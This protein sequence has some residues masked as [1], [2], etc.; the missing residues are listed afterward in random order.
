MR[1]ILSCP[2]CNASN[3]SNE[4]INTVKV[5]ENSLGFELIVTSGLRCLDCNKLAGGVSNSAHVKGEAVDIS[6]VGYNDTDTKSKMRFKILKKALLININR[7]G[8]GKT[9]IHLDVDK[10]LPQEVIFDYYG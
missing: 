2:H 4:L 7:I 6:L 5:L 1:G 10:S 3:L 9:F 8:I